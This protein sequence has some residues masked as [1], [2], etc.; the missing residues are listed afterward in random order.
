M[1]ER[2][3]RIDMSDAERAE[4]RRRTAEDGRTR[5]EVVAFCKD[6]TAVDVELINVAA[7]GEQGELTGFL[8]IHRDITERKSA[9]SNPSCA[10]KCR[11]SASALTTRAPRMSS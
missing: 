11:S 7:R 4:M 6:G 9:N 8:G 5:R 3:I 10:R 2:A 1:W